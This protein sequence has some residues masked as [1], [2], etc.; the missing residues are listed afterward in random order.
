MSGKPLPQ[1]RVDAIFRKFPE[2]R[3]YDEPN[4]FGGPKKNPGCAAG[5]RNA[6]DKQAQKVKRTK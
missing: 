1:R 3:S 2:R 6:L 5:V 4:S